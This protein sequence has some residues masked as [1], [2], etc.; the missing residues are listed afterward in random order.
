[1]NDDMTQATILLEGARS[2]IEFMRAR[3][4]GAIED[5]LDEYEQ[6]LDGTIDISFQ[7]SD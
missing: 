6:N 4:M 5:I 3:I 7:W 2:D 1:M